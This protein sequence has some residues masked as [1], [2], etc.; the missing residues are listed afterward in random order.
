MRNF[1]VV[2]ENILRSGKYTLKDLKKTALEYDLSN[3]I[4]LNDRDPFLSLKT[5]KKI[6]I[7]FFHFRISD[8]EKIS[9]GLFTDVLKIIYSTSK[10]TLIHCWK[11][12]HRTGAVIGKIRKTQHWSPMDTWDE[13]LKY[14]FGEPCE[15]I[16]LFRSVFDESFSFGL[17][18][19]KHC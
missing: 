12:A 19:S 2:Q 17:E 5:Y 7:N 11:G 1:G 3:I 15:H 13:M 16:E 18:W 14:G 4:Y 8:R 6:G 10:T 9:S